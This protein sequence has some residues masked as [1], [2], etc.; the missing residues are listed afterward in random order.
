[1]PCFRPLKAYR[2]IDGRIVFKDTSGAMIER[3]LV[4]P[5]G[6]CVGCRLRRAQTWA[7]RCVHESKMYSENCF[8]TLTYNDLNLP[9]N[10]SLLHS[11]FQKFMKRFTERVRYSGDKRKVRFYMCGEYGEKFGR[12]HYHACIFN[13]DFPDKVYKRV[14]ALGDKIY[15]SEFLDDCWNMSDPGVC[16]IGSVSI[17]SA[18]YV[19][20]YIMKKITGDDAVAYYGDLVPEYTH[21]SKGIG[22][23]W[24]DKNWKD[25]YPSDFVIHDGR[26]FPA[27]RYYDGLFELNHPSAFLGLRTKRLS[28]SGNPLDVK[29][30][31]KDRRLRVREDVTKL[32]V[33]RLKKEL[34]Q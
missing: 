25:V 19:A 14:N 33:K 27:P 16:E 2:T 10:G 17:Q 5:C 7:L 18:G 6:Q 28:K 34:D 21:M 9:S 31:D 20:R 24:F 29:D 1:M 23:A 15:T 12:P 22:K 8:I 4:L 32:R 3:P 30:D 26:R 13:Y 11:D